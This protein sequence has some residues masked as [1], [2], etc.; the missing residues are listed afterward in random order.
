MAEK[1]Q[2]DEAVAGLTLNLSAED[3][4]NLMESL[5]SGE[6]KGGAGDLKGGGAK[7]GGCGIVVCGN[8]AAM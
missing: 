8:G 2:K 6:S 4:K 5:N 1:D 7:G 3:L